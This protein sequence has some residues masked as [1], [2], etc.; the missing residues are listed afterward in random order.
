MH[1]RHRLI[2]PASNPIFPLRLTP[3]DPD[4]LLI[5]G[6]IITLTV[7][8]QL[9]RAVRARMERKQDP[10]AVLEVRDRLRRLEEA[11][12][13][14]AVE[15]ERIAEGQRFTTKLLSDRV[16]DRVPAPGGQSALPPGTSQRR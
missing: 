5:F 3:M 10:E 8:Y 14:I 12:D 4:L 11:V 6:G 2:P 1:P 7:G 13:A 15:V 16:A 9:S